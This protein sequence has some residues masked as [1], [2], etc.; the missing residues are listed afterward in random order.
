MTLSNSDRLK[1][2]NALASVG[3]ADK[4]HAAAEAAVTRSQS[5]CTAAAAAKVTEWD[6]LK[7]AYPGLKDGDKIDAATGEVT[8]A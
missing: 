7:A 5:V 6:A 2:L 3:N 1:W 4:Q 8:P